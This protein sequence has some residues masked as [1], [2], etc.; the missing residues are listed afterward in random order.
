[1]LA[2]DIFATSNVLENV[3]RKIATLREGSRNPAVA[4]L[5]GALI[6]FGFLKSSPSKIAKADGIF[7]HGTH[8]AVLVSE[9][10]WDVGKS[11]TIAGIRITD[12]FMGEFHR[13]GLA[14]EFD[15]RGSFQRHLTWPKGAAIPKPQLDA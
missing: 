12:E 15:C 1:M 14:R 4:L 7:G 8:L 11:V 3:A 2:Y 5:Q 6:E 10:N 13:Q 9:Y